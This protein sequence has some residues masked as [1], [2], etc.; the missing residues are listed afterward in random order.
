MNYPMYNP[1]FMHVPDSTQKLISQIRHYFHTTLF[2]KTSLLDQHIQWILN[3]IHYKIN[4]RKI[5]KGFLRCKRILKADNL[6]FFI[7]SG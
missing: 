2:I 5:R 7:Q 1:S 4:F 6:Y 3:I